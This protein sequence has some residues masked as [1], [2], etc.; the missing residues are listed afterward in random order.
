MRE[1]ETERERE[2]ETERDRERQRVRDEWRLLTSVVARDI[3]NI[4]D[5]LE[6]A[7]AAVKLGNIVVS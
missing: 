4:D 7:T 2:R 5:D 1:R 3:R 6:K